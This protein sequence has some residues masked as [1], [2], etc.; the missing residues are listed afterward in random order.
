[1]RYALE[2]PWIYNYKTR[3]PGKFSIRVLYLPQVNMMWRDQR[4]RRVL[5]FGTGAVLTVFGDS[6]W[7]GAFVFLEAARV[8]RTGREGAGA[9]GAVL[10]RFFGTWR[11]P[12][13]SLLSEISSLVLFFAAVVGLYWILAGIVL[14]ACLVD[15]MGAT[16]V[17]VGIG[18]VDALGAVL[19]FRTGATCFGTGALRVF[20]WLWF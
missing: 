20:C 1:M 16:T 14:K 19:D 5:V 2:I 17:I 18:F 13:F 11:S 4:G 15:L 8:A 9:M 12:P 7:V 6:I 3:E 10:V